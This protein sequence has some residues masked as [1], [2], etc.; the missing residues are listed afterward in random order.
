MNELL[1]YQNLPALPCSVVLDFLLWR[2]LPA[3][4]RLRLTAHRWR[5][6]RLRRPISKQTAECRQWDSGQPPATELEDEERRRLEAQRI[7]QGLDSRCSLQI[8]DGWSQRGRWNGGTNEQ[9]PYLS[10]LLVYWAAN[11]PILSGTIIRGTLRT[12][13]SQLVTPISIKLQRPDGH[14]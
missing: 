11:G 5:L 3:W 6:L 9:S 2:C 10:I 14:D 12:P 8:A 4:L 7:H 13:N 1:N